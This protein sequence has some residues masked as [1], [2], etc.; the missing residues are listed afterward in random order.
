MGAIE[1]A[2]A[3][4]QQE[5][6]KKPQSKNPEPNLK[7]LHNKE[8]EHPLFLLQPVSGTIPLQEP[9]KGWRNQL[10]PSANQSGAKQYR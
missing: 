3:N 5:K 9:K 6:Y 1:I 2:L 10:S 7:T 4:V 8:Q